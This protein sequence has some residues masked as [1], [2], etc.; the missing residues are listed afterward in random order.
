MYKPHGRK[1]S[2]QIRS[3][4]SVFGFFKLRLYP[5]IEI[6][7]D[8]NLLRLRR[9]DVRAL[10]CDVAICPPLLFQFVPSG[11]RCGHA[12]DIPGSKKLRRHPARHGARQ[13][14]RVAHI[15][16][17]SPRHA[18]APKLISETFFTSGGGKSRYFMRGI[19]EKVLKRKVA[20]KQNLPQI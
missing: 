9:K 17:E 15:T 1:C 4:E 14:F 13:R 3:I 19:N 11:A 10:V 7:A 5:Y 8:C 20:K 18:Q 6:F 16:P 2:W 12:I